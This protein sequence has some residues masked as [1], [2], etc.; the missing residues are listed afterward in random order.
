MYDVFQADRLIDVWLHEDIGSCDLT[1]QLMIDEN[2]TSTFHMLA[3][4]PMFIA[5]INVA[6]RVFTRYDSRLKVQ[7]FFKD[8]QHANKGDKLLTVQGRR[9]AF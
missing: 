4:E 2:A 8:G 3:R 9:V 1:A 6:E 7:T 5:G